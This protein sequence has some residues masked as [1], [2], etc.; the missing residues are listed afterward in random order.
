MAILPALLAL[1]KRGGRVGLL[2][3][4]SVAIEVD[5]ME[6]S[7]DGVRLDRDNH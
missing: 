4:S 5:G 7:S 6:H 1:C 2:D 3:S